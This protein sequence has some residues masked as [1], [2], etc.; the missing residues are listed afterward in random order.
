MVIEKIQKYLSKLMIDNVLLI[1][2]FAIDLINLFSYYG[3]KFII[4]KYVYFVFFF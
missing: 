2:I 1:L 4:I 3:S